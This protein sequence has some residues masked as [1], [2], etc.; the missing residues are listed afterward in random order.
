MDIS[1]DNVYAAFTDGI[2]RRQYTGSAITP[3]ITVTFSGNAGT[4]NLTKDKDYSVTYSNNTNAGKAGVKITGI[5]NYSGSKELDFAIFANLNDKTSV[6]TIPKQMYTGEPIT[7]LSGAT[8]KAGGNDLKA[9]SDYTL[10]I[11]S[12]DAFRTKGTASAVR[13]RK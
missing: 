4:V 12:T 9:G 10:S 3:A 1:G 13:D 8:I 7:E 6:F 2:T 5:G 11:T